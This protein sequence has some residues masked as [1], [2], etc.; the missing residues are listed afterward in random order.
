MGRGNIE[1]HDL[2]GAFA[3]M[4]RG[5]RSRIAGIDEVDELHALDDTASVNIEAGDDALGDHYFPS[6]E[7]KLLRIFSPVAPDFSGWNCTP[8]TL[9]RSTADANGS[10]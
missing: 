7:R 6:Q 10:M 2:V 3:G 8:I 1:Q 4:A 5:L 9:A